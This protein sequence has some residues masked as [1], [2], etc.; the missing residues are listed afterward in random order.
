MEKTPKVFFFFS[1]AHSA[2]TLTTVDDGLQG[3]GPANVVVVGG[4][5]VGVSIAYHLAKAGLKNVVLLEKSEL[6]AGSTWH[7]VKYRLVVWG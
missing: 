1:S 6:T 5:V 3:D 4:G 7:A 2:R